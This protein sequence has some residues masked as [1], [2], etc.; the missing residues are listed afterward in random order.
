MG[1]GHPGATDRQATVRT[2]KSRAQSSRQ[3]SC[4]SIRFNISPSAPSR[5]KL[6][7]K[8]VS[9]LTSPPSPEL[10]PPNK[11][12]PKAA[13]LK[14]S[15]STSPSATHG[16]TAAK[17]QR[18]QN[19]E[20]TSPAR[21]EWQVYENANSQVRQNEPFYS[22]PI[23]IQNEL[24]VCRRTAHS[25]IDRLSQGRDHSHDMPYLAGSTKVS[26]HH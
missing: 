16:L 15:N 20:M 21:L 7:R 8:D 19:S 5:S 23:E 6:E 17:K 18:L 2:S 13:R 24:H 9:F 11:N 4:M 10:S 3:H 26:V 14:G 25:N 22:R 12:S 1:E